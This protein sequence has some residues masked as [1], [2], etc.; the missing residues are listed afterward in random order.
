[1]PRRGESAEPDF[2]VDASSRAR[3]RPARQ[4]Q[5]DSSSN[6]LARGGHGRGSRR[7]AKSPLR[8]PLRQTAPRCAVHSRRSPAS[9]P[10]SQHHPRVRRS[11]LRAPRYSSKVASRLARSRSQ[12]TP[13]EGAGSTEHERRS[14]D[15][16]ARE[17]RHWL[18]QGDRHGPRRN[19]TRGPP[20][21]DELGVDSPSQGYPRFHCGAMRVV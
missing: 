18:L 9:L 8:V 4:A 20:D 3:F 2:H 10:L 7:A 12:P 14:S 6:E 17:V 21:R 15:A 19:S 5:R 1:M 11:P 13:A 16:Q